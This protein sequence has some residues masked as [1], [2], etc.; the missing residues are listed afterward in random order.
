VLTLLMMKVGSSRTGLWRNTAG[1]ELRNVSRY[2]IPATSAVLRIE[3]IEGPFV[4]ESREVNAMGCLLL[5][6]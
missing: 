6:R 2:R 1:M 3:S 5:G 4:A